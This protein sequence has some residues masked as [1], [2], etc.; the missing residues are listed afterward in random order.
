M[1]YSENPDTAALRRQVEIEVRKQRRAA[2][3][4]LFIANLIIFLVFMMLAWVIV[5]S[6]ADIS[7]TDD[8]MAIMI[9]L[10]IG[11]GVGLLLHSMSARSMSKE[12]ERVVRRRTARRLVQDAMLGIS[13]DDD[14]LLE[15]APVEKAKRGRLIEISDEGE[16]LDI[17]DD[18]DR[19][20]ADDRRG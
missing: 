14:P 18:D 20:L 10:S 6:T 11:W 19:L 12:W 2:Q 13:D 15:I 1:R 7:F 4:G 3:T 17:L 8:H 9:I 16:I 5:P